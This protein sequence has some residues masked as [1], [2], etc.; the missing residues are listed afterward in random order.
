MSGEVL[1]VR[2]AEVAR[3][4]HGRCYGSSDM[5]LSREGLRQTRTLAAELAQRPLTAIVHSGLR[6]AAILA[7]LVAGMTGLPAEAD[8]RWRERDFGEWEGRSWAR[9]WRETGDA[10]DGMITDPAG[11]R[12]GGGET[13]AELSARS[14]AAWR[15]LPRQGIVLVVSHG[16]PI[17][18]LRAFMAGLPP[19]EAARFI[20][21][22]GSAVTLPVHHESAA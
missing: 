20:P 10:M 8:P 19:R 21:A 4:W 18:M 9:I 12:P 5:G 11:F 1:L 7:D 17:A 15:G 16:G 14:R 3:R 6:R 22:T 13:S 2:H